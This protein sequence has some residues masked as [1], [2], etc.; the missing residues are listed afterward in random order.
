MQL[1]CVHS[2]DPLSIYPYTSVVNCVAVTQLP[3]T[4]VEMSSP[5]HR[6]RM[7]SAKAEDEATK[8]IARNMREWGIEVNSNK[9]HAKF[10]NKA[11]KTIKSCHSIKEASPAANRS[12]T[13][14]MLSRKVELL[15]SKLYSR[16][17]FR[18]CQRTDADS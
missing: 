12:S 18:A 13:P 4:T 17:R 2:W 5:Q 16:K 1:L 15:L 8:E 10:A 6:Y 9:F 3:A 7:A 14:K 11:L